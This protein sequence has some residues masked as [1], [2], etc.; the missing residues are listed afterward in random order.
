MTKEFI[1]GIL[2]PYFDDPTTCAV[3]EDGLCS[4]LT[5][6]GRKCAVGKMLKEGS[7][8]TYVGDVTGLVN[9]YGKDI[10]KKDIEVSNLKVLEHMQGIHDFLASKK[11]GITKISIEDLQEATGFEFPELLNHKILQ[12]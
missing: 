4:Y 1:L 8:Q 10:F 2:L 9:R 6:D 7:W 5:E 11:Y 12:Q 3:N